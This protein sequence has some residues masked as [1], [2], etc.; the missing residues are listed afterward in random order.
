VAELAELRLQRVRDRAFELYREG[1]EAEADAML[2]D[3]G[4]QLQQLLDELQ[5]SERSQSRLHSKRDEFS[6]FMQMS[7]IN[8]KRKRLAEDRNRAARDR[9][10]FRDSN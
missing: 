8:E 5:L 3:A 1:K 4:L 6:S 9:K 2:R 7:N 10:N